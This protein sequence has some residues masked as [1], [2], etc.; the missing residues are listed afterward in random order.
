MKRHAGLSRLSREHHTALVLAKRAMRLADTQD[1]ARGDFM[2]EVTR[3]F[4]TEYEPHFQAEEA[5]LLPALQAAGHADLVTRTLSEHAALRALASRLARGEAD[6]LRAFGEAME[7][8][9]RFEERE[10][11][12]RAESILPHALLAEI[13]PRPDPR[14]A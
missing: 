11:F 6:C 3:R 12:P 7:A 1:A 8:H 9:V 13:D 2:A 4:C 14:R 10:L 5:R